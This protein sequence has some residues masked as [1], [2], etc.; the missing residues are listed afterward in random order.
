MYIAYHRTRGEIRY[1]LRESV[2]RDNCFEKRELL[3][4]GP[5][6]EDFIEYPGGNSF[7]IQEEIIDQLND[8]GLDPGL[9]E[10][11]AVFWPFV[12]PEIRHALRGFQGRA[13]YKKMKTG[14]SDAEY[15]FIRNRLHLVD[16]RRLNYLRLGYIDQTQLHRVSDKLY[17]PLVY[18]SR[19]ELEQWFIRQEMDLSPREYSTYVYS[20]LNLRRHFYEIFAGKM[21]QALDQEKMDRVFMQ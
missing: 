21:P 3:D 2:L 20:F 19:D 14:L 15:E 6:P 9:Q 18:K 13:Q 4:L 5:D 16:K 1:Y 10:L 7:Y 12:D 17:Q 11:E 8:L